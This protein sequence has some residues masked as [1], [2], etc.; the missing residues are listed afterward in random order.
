[1]A[2]KEEDEFYRRYLKGW[3]E[4]EGYA[5]IESL[6]QVRYLSCIHFLKFY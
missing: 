4:E 6:Y 2:M 1:M 5:P 3:R